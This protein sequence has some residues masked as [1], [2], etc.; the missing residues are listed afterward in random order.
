[1]LSTEKILGIEYETICVHA[2]SY[3]S[4]APGPHALLLYILIADDDVG[5]YYNLCI[6][7][8]RVFACVC[9]RSVKINNGKRNIY[10]YIYVVNNNIFHVRKSV[11]N[12]IIPIRNTRVNKNRV[13]FK[14]KVKS[15]YALGTLNIIISMLLYR[16]IKFPTNMHVYIIQFK[17]VNAVTI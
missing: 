13:E 4:G 15:T 16:G 8:Q 9:V 11:G 3:G 14:R 12:V 2:L 5:V 1:M 17:F 6:S 7:F 10:I